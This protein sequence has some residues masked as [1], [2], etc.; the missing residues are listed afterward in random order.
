MIGS[1]TFT[2]NPAVQPSL[3]FDPATDFA[4][5]AMLG[6]TPLVL[7]TGPA[8]DS[9]TLDEFM[10]VAKSRDLKYATSGLGN[11]NQFAAELLNDAAGLKMTP[12]HYKGGSEAMT[13]VIGGHVDLF[14][15]SMT[16]A[17]PLIRDGQMNGLAVTGDERAEAAPEIPTFA[18]EGV[19][20]MNI[21]QWWGI[22][23][24]AG[25]PDD[26]VQKLN[27]D[28][29]TV[30]ESDKTKEFLAKDGAVPVPMEPAEFNDFVQSELQKWADIAEKAGIRAQ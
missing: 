25:I 3:P 9:K 8:V 28:I 16:Q 17:L 27:D 10:E 11:V 2:M 26:V 13:D 7:V 15:S 20:G 18:E 23:A 5:V 14:M 6:R 1:V 19:E 24:P 30:L 12:V 4:P 21:G 29:N 22:F